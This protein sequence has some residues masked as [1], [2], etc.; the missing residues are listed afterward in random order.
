MT[1]IWKYEIPIDNEWH[2]LEISAHIYHIA[3]QNAGTLELWAL[4]EGPLVTRTFKAFG[5]GHE[6]DLDVVE[7]QYI[8]T[9][10]YHFL[11]MPKANPQLGDWTIPLVEHPY[12]WHLFEKL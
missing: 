5:T 6:F 7:M 11:R 3:C 10:L 8:G 4:N 9:A 2:S 1:A 12:V